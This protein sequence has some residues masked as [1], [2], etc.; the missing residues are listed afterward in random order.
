VEKFEEDGLVGEK[1]FRDDLDRF[2][3]AHLPIDQ[4]QSTYAQQFQGVA[5]RPDSLILLGAA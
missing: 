2:G 5:K 4:D 1:H 3:V